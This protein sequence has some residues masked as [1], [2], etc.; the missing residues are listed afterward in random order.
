MTLLP[1]IEEAREEIEALCRRFGVQRLEI[2]GSA[3]TGSFKP[4]ES[5]LDFLVEFESPE[6]PGYSNR[7]FGLLEALE[8]RFGRSVDLVVDSSISNPYFR[9]SVEQSRTLLYAA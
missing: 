1:E 5:D 4:D 7:Y 9:K 3:V 8:D 2:F 6:Q